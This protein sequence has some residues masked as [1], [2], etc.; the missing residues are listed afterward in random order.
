VLVDH[1]VWIA[2]DVVPLQVLA[3]EAESRR[4][5][6]LRVAYDEVDLGVVEERVLVQVRGADRQPLVVDDADLRVHV[7]GATVR[8]V[9][10]ERRGVQAAG[11]AVR[12]EEDA[13]LAAR[14][15]GA[16]VRQTSRS[17]ARRARRHDSAIEN[18]PR[19]SPP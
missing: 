14:V 9:L 15:V 13:E 7:D 8:A 1:D 18:S 6:R 4:A 3:P 19:G 5:R 12:L 10:V 2:V 11:A 17:A 16:V